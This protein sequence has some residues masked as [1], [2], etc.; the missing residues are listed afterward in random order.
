[1]SIL[2]IKDVTYGY[3]KLEHILFEVNQNFECGKF[4]AIIGKSGAGKSTLL[5][6]LA[7][8]DEP[9]S[10]EILFEGEDISKTGYTKAIP[11][12]APKESRNPASNKYN[13]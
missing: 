2:E 7:G 13:G 4:Y 6:L 9:D 1:M 11:A 5:S 3:T 12:N 8:L 10:G